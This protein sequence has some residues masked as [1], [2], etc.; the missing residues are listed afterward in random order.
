MPELRLRVREIAEQR[1]IKSASE[2]SR[3]TKIAYAT[4][5]RMWRGDLG[6]EDK[7]IGIRVLYRVARALG[8][9]FS[10]LVEETSGQFIPQQLASALA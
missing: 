4:A 8:V 1:G 5:Y 2:L 3:E 6:S 9:R 10:E 7:G